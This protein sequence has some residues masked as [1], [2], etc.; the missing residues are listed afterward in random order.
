METVVPPGALGKHSGKKKND[1]CKKCSGDVK[2]AASGHVLFHAELNIWYC[3]VDATQKNG[4]TALPYEQWCELNGQKA[5]TACQNSRKRKK[6]REEAPAAAE[7]E[8]LAPGPAPSKT[9]KKKATQGTG[10][11]VGWQAGR[12]VGG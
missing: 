12:W 1:V 10:G 8:G 7:A 11:G 6:A 5:I 9:K 3:P 2:D 4:G